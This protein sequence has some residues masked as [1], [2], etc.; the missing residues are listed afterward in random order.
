MKKSLSIALIAVSATTLVGYSKPIDNQGLI[1]T[2]SLVNA[3]AKTETNGATKTPVN[4]PI[5]APVKTTPAPAAN[6]ALIIPAGTKFNTDLEQAI[7]TG[8]NKNN[9]R[10]TLKIKNGSVGKYPILKD[11]VIEGHL[12]DVS[13]AARGKKAKLNLVFDA[14]KLKNGDT[15]PIDAI[16]LNTKI[17]TKTKGK[18][19]KNAAT[20]IGGAVAGKFVGDKTKFKHGGLAGGAAAAAYVLSSPGGEVELKK[21]TDVELKLK[22]KLDAN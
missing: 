8:K 6:P 15:F 12:E 5:K 22:T 17:E 19:L 7:S 13:K 9:D 20:I 18:F 10:F 1:G 21:G 11:A 3:I 2:A 4:T 16:L 14:I